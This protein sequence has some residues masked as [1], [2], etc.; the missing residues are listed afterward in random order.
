LHLLLWLEILVRVLVGYEGQM[1]ML[2]ISEGVAGNGAVARAPSSLGALCVVLA[3]RQRQAVR[4]SDDIWL[5]RRRLSNVTRFDMRHN[6]WRRRS[7]EING[8]EFDPV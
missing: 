1:Y 6:V 4:E 5:L 8:V 7:R 2:V 3:D